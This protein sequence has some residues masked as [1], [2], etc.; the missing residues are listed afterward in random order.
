MIDEIV[1]QFNE[2]CAKTTEDCIIEAIAK[3]VDLHLMNIYEMITTELTED[4]C[5]KFNFRCKVSRI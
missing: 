3:G 2:R 1:N 5:V 4:N